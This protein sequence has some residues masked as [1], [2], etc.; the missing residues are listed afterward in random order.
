MESP[1]KR[2]KKKKEKKLR[3]SLG[4]LISSTT[5]HGNHEQLHHSQ[6]TD[7]LRL[8]NL[9]NY[10]QQIA[11]HLSDPDYDLYMEYNDDS[12]YL[13]A[14]QGGDIEDHQVFRRNHWMI[15]S[16]ATN[17]LTPFK[18]D[19]VHLFDQTAIATVA[20]GHKVKMYGPGKVILKQE[21]YS[22][23]ITLNG[24]WHV[25]SARHRLMSVPALTKNGF[26]CEIDLRFG[27][28]R[29]IS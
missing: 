23:P 22:Q 26:R 25:P 21:G 5:H 10:A 18:E 4:G 19:F 2:G 11:S 16:G 20:N 12:H 14:L 1:I 6:E 3:I 17:H 9:C 15:D 27:I 8:K 13:C 7:S 24:V 29:E 28:I